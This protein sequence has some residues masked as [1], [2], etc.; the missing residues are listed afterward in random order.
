M[1]CLVHQGRSVLLNG[2]FQMNIR[3]IYK[4]IY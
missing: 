1:L 4:K 2:N 3:P